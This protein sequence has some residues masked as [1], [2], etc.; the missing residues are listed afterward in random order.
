[1]KRMRL[2]RWAVG[3]GLAAVVAG[4]GWITAGVSAATPSGTAVHSPATFVSD[5][6]GHLGVST[7]TL[8]TAFRQTELDRVQTLLSNGRIS[9]AQAQRMEAR[10]QSAAVVPLWRAFAGHLGR[11]QRVRRAPLGGVLPGAAHYLGMTVAQVRADLTNGQSLAAIANG[12]SGKSAA[13][14]QAALVADAQGRLG[15]LVSQGKLSASQEQARLTRLEQALP[16]LLA[17]TGWMVR[18][19]PLGGVLPGAAH[20]LGMTVAQVRADLTNGQSLAAIANG[21]SGKSAAGLQAA[22]VADAQG[23]LGSL[24]SQGK[25][26]ANQEQAR[27]TRLEQ[28]LPHLLARTGWAGRRPEGPMRRSDAAD[29]NNLVSGGAAAGATGASAGSVSGAAG[30]SGTNSGPS[31]VSTSGTVPGSD[32]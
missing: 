14:L 15:S 23:R 26:S 16:H 1:M 7:A 19:A 21:V 29:A 27:L 24:V 25:L 3:A 32:A 17:R 28:A 30:M 5:L 20:Y 11:G 18:R 13:G 4:S 31:A 6:A 2:P 12:V 8:Q 9:A 22:L 10:I